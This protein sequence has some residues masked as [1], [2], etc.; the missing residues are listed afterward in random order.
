MGTVRHVPQRTCIACRQERAKRE[1]VRIVRSPLGHVTLDPSGKT[2]GRGAYLCRNATCWSAAVRRGLL[3]GALKTTLTPE[4]RATLE[5]FRDT[6][7]P[8]QSA[9]VVNA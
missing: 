2:P 5:H 6:L 4:D 1:L 8:P 9:P 7:V 3:S